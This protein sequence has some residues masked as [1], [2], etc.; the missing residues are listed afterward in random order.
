[1]KKFMFIIITVLEIKLSIR[2]FSLS[3]KLVKIFKTQ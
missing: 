3:T 2:I 1:M